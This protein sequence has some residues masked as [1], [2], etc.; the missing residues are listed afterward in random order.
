MDLLTPEC[1]TNKGC[2]STGCYNVSNLSCIDQ[3]FDLKGLSLDEGEVLQLSLFWP[4]LVANEAVP[5]DH[6]PAILIETRVEV[7]GQVMSCG[8]VHC[9]PKKQQRLSEYRMQ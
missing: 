8:H 4:P 1:Y 2:H 3:L 9:D 6:L 7:E 5:D